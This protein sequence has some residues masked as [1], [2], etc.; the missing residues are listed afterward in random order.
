MVQSGVNS[1]SGAQTDASVRKK[2][3]LKHIDPQVSFDQAGSILPFN[4]KRSISFRTVN[5][6][7]LTL[8]VQRIY[9]NNLG[10]F[11]QVNTLESNN[12]NYW[13]YNQL[14]RVAEEVHSQVVAVSGEQGPVDP[15]RGRVGPV[16]GGCAQGGV[17]GGTE[18]LG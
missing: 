1:L 14:Q 18:W 12:N 13:R 5:V 9:A 6:D 16:A 7:S 17:R 2:F 8:S 4:G 10:Q 15:H 11:L 3:T